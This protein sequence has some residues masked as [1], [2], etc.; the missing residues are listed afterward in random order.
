[1]S[2]AQHI[3]AIMEFVAFAERLKR[4]LRHSWLSDGRHES[5][6]E[7]CW[8]MSIL[9][10]LLAPHLEHTV[11][12]ARALPMVLVH[13]IVEAEVGDI[14][15]FEVSARKEQK[16]QL[17]NDAIDRIRQRLN[18]PA[19]E[20]IWRLWHEFEEGETAEAKFA[21]AL[22]ALEAQM[23]HNLANISTWLP[24]EHELTYTKVLPTCTHDAFLSDFARAVIAQ[25][26]EKMEVAGIDV[27]SL[28]Q[29]LKSA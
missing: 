19:G 17:E 2:S 8:Q 13:D 28:Q 14:P 10:M 23:Q 16:K 3:K 22:D 11:D 29:K 4:E 6:A 12:L 15:F 9:G 25:A 7:H 26:G 21:R 27:P 24:I 1:M 18:S 20:Q 5:V